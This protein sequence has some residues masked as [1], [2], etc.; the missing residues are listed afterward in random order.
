MRQ[1]LRRREIVSKKI[2]GGGAVE[3][4]IGKRRA[5]NLALRDP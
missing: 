2:K 1:G 4:T 3:E 5:P